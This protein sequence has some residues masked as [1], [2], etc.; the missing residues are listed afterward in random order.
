MFIAARQQPLSAVIPK[1]EQSFG[2]VILD[3]TGLTGTYDF[4]VE[5]GA[6]VPALRNEPGRLAGPGDDV[7]DPRPTLA[8][9]VE[10]DLGLKLEEKKSLVDILVIDRLNMTPTAN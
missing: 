5:L 8:K 10:V 3:K 6:T 4:A 7:S 2:H 1:L 9:I